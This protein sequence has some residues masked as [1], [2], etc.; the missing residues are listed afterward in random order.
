MTAVG[1][2]RKNNRVEQRPLTLRA[3]QGPAGHGAPLWSGGNGGAA[4]IEYDRACGA[5]MKDAGCGTR[6]RLWRRPEDDVG[7]ASS[8]TIMSIVNV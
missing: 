2:K 7:V 5:G 4:G 8:K 3:K 1:R 6:G